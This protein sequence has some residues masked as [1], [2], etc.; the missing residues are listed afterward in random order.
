MNSVNCNGVSLRYVEKLSQSNSSNPALVFLHNAGTDHTIWNPVADILS[1]NYNVYQLDWPGYG[2][3]RSTVSDHSLSGYA[4]LLAEFLKIIPEKDLVLV[5]N[6]LGSGTSLEYCLN[7]K[8][9][10]A[11]ALVLFNVL[12]PMTL[13]LEGKLFFA[14]SG[15][16]LQPFFQMVKNNLFL[17]ELMQGVPV[18]YQIHNEASVHPDTR[19][20]LKSLYSDPDN[21][22]NLGSL[23]EALHSSESLNN[24]LKPKNFPP[25]KIIWGEQNRVLPVQDGRKF[26]KNF[27]PTEFEVLEGGHLVM[28]EQPELSAQ[29]IDDFIRR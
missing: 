6:C 18:Q 28:L 9:D 5:G 23:V 1:K 22:R 8:D 12:V 24:P 2:Q 26:A 15:S 14:W 3:E 21:I 4:N 27:K 20:Y 10:R 17:P 7:T 19:H 13:G 29:K 11:K 25:C 16:P